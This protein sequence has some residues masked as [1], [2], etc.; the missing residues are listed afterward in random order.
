MYIN[1]IDSM[2]FGIFFFFRESDC[3]T[4]VIQVNEQFSSLAKE[5]YGRNQYCAATVMEREHIFTSE[6][7][8]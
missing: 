7:R 2:R 5:T 8:S 4:S 3:R 1:V 6:E